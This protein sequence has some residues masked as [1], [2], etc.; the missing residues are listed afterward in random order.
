VAGERIKLEV[1]EREDR[2]SRES[3]RLRRQG[4]IPGVLYGRGNNPHAICVAEREL[5]RVLTGEHGLHAILD[6]VLDGQKST[7][8]SVLK[9]VQRDAVRGTITHFDLQEV[10]LDQ[11]IRAQVVVELVGEEP[12]GVTEGGVLSQVAR[13]VTV[14]ALPMEMP[15]RL[16]LDVSSG[17]MGATFRVADVKAEGATI[18]DDPETVLATITA[19]TRVVEP[20]PEVEELEEGEL[21]EG[22]LP[23]GEV[24][25]GEAAEE[26]AEAP[27]EEAASG[28]A[29][30]PGIT[31][32]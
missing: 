5:R 14:E 18:L 7:H 29:G 1:R 19:P 17:E 12:P 13:E 15:D 27:A 2:G 9:E 28:P 6:V 24:P 23:E 3:R 22:E 16:E 10:R 25:E 4:L 31:E 20:E 32:G 30:Q 26:G 21:P 8:S 11:P